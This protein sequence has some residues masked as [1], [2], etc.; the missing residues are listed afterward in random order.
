METKVRGMLQ[1]GKIQQQDATM[2]LGYPITGVS[3]PKKKTRT[4][5]D[6]SKK[7]NDDAAL[8]ATM[9]DTKADVPDEP[10]GMKRPEE[11]EAAKD[12][13][14]PRPAFSTLCIYTCRRDLNMLGSTRTLHT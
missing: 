14:A 10:S 11:D 4:D 2:L 13:K 5:D 1:A 12:M 7:A 3:P 9:E 8:D 6:D